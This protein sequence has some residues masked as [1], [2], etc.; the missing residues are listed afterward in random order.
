MRRPASIGPFAW[1]TSAMSTTQWASFIAERP[2]LRRAEL[3]PAAAPVQVARQQR[4]VAVARQ[5]VAA[6]AAVPLRFRAASGRARLLRPADRAGSLTTFRP[7]A[8]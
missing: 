3:P 1:S 5:R 7:K 2:A 6:V 8:I 4:V